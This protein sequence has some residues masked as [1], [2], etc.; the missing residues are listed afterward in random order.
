MPGSFRAPGR[1]QP[2]TGLGRDLRVRILN[3]EF[4]VQ[5]DSVSLTDLSFLSTEPMNR[6]RP[7]KADFIPSCSLHG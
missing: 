7:L 3:V 4:A 1:R 6:G 2:Y 5:D